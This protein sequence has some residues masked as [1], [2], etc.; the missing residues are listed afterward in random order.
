[1]FTILTDISWL[2]VLLAFVIY[3]I[4][5]ALWFTVFFPKLYKISLGK[6]NDTTQSTAP[7]FF[8]GPALCC[9]VIT[10][11]SALLVYALHIETYQS[12]FQFAV[13]VGVGYLFSNTVNIAI[14]PNIPRPI[15]YG[16][17]SGSYHLVGIILVSIILLA[18]K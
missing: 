16:L 9:L 13:I 4:L 8:V 3:F 7:I 1:M 10:I 18:M 15:L 2:S 17:I 5:G 14:N 11:A 6:E 12:A